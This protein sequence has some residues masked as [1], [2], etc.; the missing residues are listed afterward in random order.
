LFTIPN[1]SDVEDVSQAQPDARDFSAMLVP[2]FSGTGIFNGCAVT[3]QGTPNM[4]VA[5]AAGTVAVAGVTTP[6]TGGNVPITAAN[7]TNPRFDLICVDASGTKSAVAGTPAAAP[8]FPDPAGKVVLAAVR[9]PNGASSI[10]AAKIV[11]K[12]VQTLIVAAT[13]LAGYPNDVRKQ[14]NGDSSWSY[15]VI[16]PSSQTA[17]YTLV[18]TDANLVIE[19]NL[20]TA[21]TLTIPPNASVAFPLGSQ[22]EVG[23]MGAGQTTIA[24][25]SGVT[26]RAYNNNL[27]LAGQYAMCSLIKRG[28]DD[29]WVAGN[30][31]P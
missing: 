13:S 21:N 24:G 10:N 29:W 30:L 25:G 2:A 27:K 17:N 9:I 20:A 19:M 5:V 14:L 16:P 31:V 7:A 6:V 22:I 3:A 1:S 15:P 11:D 26:L 23:Q 18:L 28:T 4:T 8:V 12:R